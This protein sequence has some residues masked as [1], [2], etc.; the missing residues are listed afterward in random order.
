MST[1]KSKRD[2][3]KG[4]AVG[5]RGWPGT[6]PLEL[7]ELTVLLALRVQL[8]GRDPKKTWIHVESSALEAL[9]GLSDK[10]VKK[11]IDGMLAKSV[12]SKR[13]DWAGGCWH[14]QYNLAPLVYLLGGCPMAPSQ[15][16][17]KKKKNKKLSPKE[18]AQQIQYLREHNPPFIAAEL[19]SNP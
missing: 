18:L 7:I 16:P 19:Q 5:L 4:L 12:L 10:T 1:S 13:R 9:L 17:A 15:V 2:C 11:V 8:V 3:F 14:C 6:E